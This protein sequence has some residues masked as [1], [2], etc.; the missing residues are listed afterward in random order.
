MVR[1]SKNAADKRSP[2]QAQG[3]R[4]SS[5]C[6][7]IQACRKAVFQSNDHSLRAGK[8]G[9]HQLIRNRTGKV[10]SRKKSLDEKR[11]YRTD[12]Y[13]PLKIRNELAK[14]ALEEM[15]AR[16]EQEEEEDDFD[17]Y[18]LEEGDDF[19]PYEEYIPSP[20]PKASPMPL[21]KTPQKTPPAKSPLN[22]AYTPFE[23]RISARPKKPIPPGGLRYKGL[24]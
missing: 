4:R 17:P 8:L 1:K 5:K 9:K 11:K 12:P 6:R 23:P 15:G 3:C 21:P 20:H 7:S 18:E 10:V 2:T 14:A 22:P 16:R 19:E 24:R 13:H